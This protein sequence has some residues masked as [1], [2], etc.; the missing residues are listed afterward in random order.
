MNAYY[1]CGPARQRLDGGPTVPIGRPWL[2]GS[3]CDHY[4]V[5]LPYPIGPD[6]ETCEW[7]AGL[8]P[9][10]LAIADHRICGLTA[11]TKSRP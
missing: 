9:D 11:C 3:H 1:R 4:L 8:T 2:D 10:P 5:S 7:R 6:F